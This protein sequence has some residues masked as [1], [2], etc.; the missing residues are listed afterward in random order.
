MLHINGVT[1]RALGIAAV[2]A[3]GGSGVDSVFAHG[4]IPPPGKARVE[5]GSVLDELT[6]SLPSVEVPLLALPP[7]LDERR[8]RA[9]TAFESGQ[10]RP[11]ALSP[12][13][14]YLFAANTPDGRLE[15]FRIGKDGALTPRLSVP[16]GLEP[17]AIA[18]RGDREVWVVNH[19]SDSISVVAFNDG[20]T[21]GSVRRT[22]QVGDEP[23]DIVFAGPGRTRAFIT[24][25]HR[26][27]NAPYDPQLTTPGIGRA[28]VWVFDAAAAAGQPLAILQL[29]S[30]TPR[31]LAVSPDGSRVYAAAF[32]SGNRTAPLAELSV[33]D[34]GELLGGFPG[35]RTNAAGVPAPEVGVIVKQDADGTWRDVI[36]RS[37]DHEM[38]FNL[39]D[40]DVFTI[41]ALA[42]PPALVPG[43]FGEYAGV[44]TI[45]FNMAVNPASGALYVSN[46]ES[47]NLNQFEGEGHFA[48]RT[49]RGHLAESRITVIRQGQVQPRHLNKHIDY[50]QCCAPLPNEENRRSLA[51]PVEMGVSA[52]GKALYVA[53]LGSNKVG[54][55]DTAQLEA[56]SFAPDAGSHVALS[57]G[58]PTGLIV[59]HVRG[60]LFVLTRFD[61]GISVVDPAARTETA[62]VRM[63]NPEPEKIVRGRRLLYDASITS[64][65]GDSACASCHI[66]GD[67]DSLAWDLGDPDGEV[68]RNPGPFETFALGTTVNVPF[69]HTDG[70]LPNKDFHPMKGPM[71]T[72]SLRGMAN[73]GPM[74][75]RGDRTGGNHADSAQPDSGT[76][77]EKA[78]FMAFNGAF[79]GLLGRDAMLTQA[80]MEA[81]ADFAL[82]IMYP[83]NPIRRLDNALRPL[84]AQG[85]DFFFNNVSDLGNTCQQCHTLDPDGNR[86]FT[87]KPGFFGSRGTNGFVFEP[88]FFKTAHL[89][90]LYQKVGRFGMSLIPF[91][92]PRDNEHMGDQVRGVGYNHDGV[93]DTLF[94]FESLLVF[95]HG[96][97]TSKRA[98]EAFLLAFDS[99]LA[100]VVGQ[101]LTVGAATAAAA[102]ERLSLLRARADAGECELVA[103]ALRDGRERGYLYSAGSFIQDQSALPRLLLSALLAETFAA[104]AELTFTCVPPDSGRR[105]ALDRDLD[106]VLD[107]D[108]RVAGTDPAN[109]ASRP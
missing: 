65:H 44:G 34:G 48:G 54:I 87:D 50:D 71:T 28:D 15:V 53:A 10:V 76:F 91:Q 109:P 27:Q 77:D 33:P 81:F 58:G 55:F 62:H 89:R 70:P 31:A 45:L 57:G 88:Q 9:F 98:T 75:W 22:L 105:M 86:G 69:G 36:G 97:D 32:H 79:T 24:T 1:A 40:K 63:H 107:G 74:H 6:P 39:P 47:N 78:A 68:L 4:S 46:L 14:R 59:D 52:D 17:V 37:W 13:G 5:S 18:A 99:N 2:V 21:A 49:I 96:D 60:R 26:G 102:A 67:F 104:G 35:P 41:D 106:G 92:P 29:F 108:E 20:M 82:E 8:E 101:Q 84:E 90:N 11:L 64:S 95:L 19:L 61:N 94:R 25:A 23:R 3:L 100:P 83:P 30:D 42:N 51:F 80:D 56:D 7:D 12:D 72:Q 93:F 16:V 73:H 103:K 38:R 66:F 43:V 85:R